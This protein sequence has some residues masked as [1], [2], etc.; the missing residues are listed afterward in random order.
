MSELIPLIAADDLS[1]G[2]SAEVV[3]EGRILAVYNVDG[4]FHVLDGMC[5]HAGGPLGE[6][7]AERRRGD[8]SVARMAI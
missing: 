3:A 5:A 2:E 8:V 1:P 7:R 4:V 6:G